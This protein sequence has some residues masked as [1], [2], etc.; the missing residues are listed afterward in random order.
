MTF[1][2]IN[3]KKLEEAQKDLDKAVAEVTRFKMHLITLRRAIECADQDEDTK[4]GLWLLYDDL[5][6]EKKSAESSAEWRYKTVKGILEEI[7]KA[8][9]T[10]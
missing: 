10:F 9:E 3:N 1:E 7:E 2:E 5:I 8:E 4:M 6:E